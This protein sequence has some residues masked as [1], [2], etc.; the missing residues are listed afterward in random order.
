MGTGDPLRRHVEAA[1]E[2]DDVAF[3]YLVSATQPAV[4]RLCTA[5]GSSGVEEDLVQETYLRAIKSLSTFRFEVPFQAWLL[6]IARGCAPTT[7][8]GAP[9][10]VVS[11]ID[12][13][14]TPVT[15]W[16]STTSRSTTC[17]TNSSPNA[18]MRSCSPR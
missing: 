1:V 8:A 2:G 18:V 16:H 12:S 3:S 9:V 15:V 10:P 13:T 11:P 14:S 4:W 5:L 7:S 6:S 17:S